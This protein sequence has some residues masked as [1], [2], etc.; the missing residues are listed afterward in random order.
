MCI[1]F[2]LNVEKHQK[3]FLKTRAVFN[4]CSKGN[5][6]DGSMNLLPE[7]DKINVYILRSKCVKQ[8]KCF[9][10]TRAVHNYCSKGN[11]IDGSMNVLPETDK[12]NVYI[13]RSKCGK[14]PETLS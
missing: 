14:T 9:L 7:T 6:I 3:C 1:F 2:T 5:Y 4:S 8:Q 12:I 13:L 10:K 11:Y